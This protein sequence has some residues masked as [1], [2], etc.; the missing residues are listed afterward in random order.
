MT[1]TFTAFL[2][3]EM[4]RFFQVRSF[5]ESFVLFRGESPLTV[6]TLYRKWDAV[7]LESVLV[8][9]WVRLKT[10]A[11]LLTHSLSF[12][13]TDTSQG[14]G[15]VTWA[16]VVRHTNAAILNPPLLVAFQAV[17]GYIGH[18]TMVALPVELIRVSHRLMSPNLVHGKELVPTAF[19][20]VWLLA[21]V[22]PAFM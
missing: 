4:W 1:K 8:E 14:V 17:V 9:L 2:A 6:V 20:L 21:R 5:V 13:D 19:T 11:T 7:L 3:E 10:L 15:V 18:V 22:L 12:V 16:L